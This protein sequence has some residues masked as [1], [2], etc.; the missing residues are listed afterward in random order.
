MFAFLFLHGSLSLQPHKTYLPWAVASFTSC[1]LD[2]REKVSEVPEH[3]FMFLPLRYN[4]TNKY[5]LTQKD[6]NNYG[7]Q[8]LHL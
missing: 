7:H 8:P 3:N 5:S 2:P 4:Q 6:F 1:E